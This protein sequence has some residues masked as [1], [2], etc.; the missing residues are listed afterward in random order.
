MTPPRA[1]RR[2]HSRSIHGETVADPWF[3]LRDRNDPETIA[4]L[5]A[6][7]RYTDAVM[8]PARALEAQLY[9]EMLG[10]IQ[11][12]DSSVPFLQG[13]WEYITRMEQGK[14]YP[15]H[16]RQ[17][18]G[19]ETHART[20]LD[21]NAL[22]AG[23]DYFSLAYSRVSP[24]GNV[25]AWAI[26]TDGSEVYTLRFRDLSTETSLPESITGVYYDA[27]WASDNLTFFYTT[28]DETRRPHR[29]WRHTL[30]SAEA[31][32]LV[33]EEPD[34]RFNVSIDRTR[35]GRFLLLNV[36]SHTTTE[37]R[38][39]DAGDATGEFQLLRPRSQDVEYFIEHQGGYFWMRTN[40]KAVNF[41]LLRA[42]DT[43]PGEWTEVLAHNEEVTLEGMDGFR[44]HLAITER[45]DG[46]RRIRVIHTPDMAQH[47]VPFEEPVYTLFP[48]RNEEYD[49]ATL[50]FL[51]TSLVTPR[52]VYDYDMST[53]ERELKKRYAVLGGYDP[54]QYVS[55]RIFATAPDGRQVP[56]SLVYRRGMRRDGTNPLYLNGYGSYGIVTE[57]AFSSDRISLLDRGFVFAIAHIRGSADKGR[58]W[59]ETG[60]LLH[61][62]NT[63]TD[64]IA[65]AE[66]LVAEGYTSPG[67]LV[68]VGGSAGGLLMGA[69]TNMRPDLFHAVVAHVPF[70]DVVNTMLDETLPLTVTEYEEWGNPNEPAFY[71]YI[72]SY[73]P[74]ENVT[75][76]H[77][78]HILA[79]AGLNDPRVPYWEPAKWVARLRE[80]ATGDRTMLLKTIMGAGHS[81]PSGRY[82]R[83]A[84][85]AFEYAFVLNVLE[86]P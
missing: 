9:A 47:L 64:F 67:K 77:Y 16:C 44:E 21:C 65:A 11:E 57:P 83:L 72:R 39:L 71:Q 60:K 56:V 3:W 34:A 73:A 31:D 55:E 8:A 33:F 13:G 36:N 14:Q 32:T 49:T 30:G 81:G 79:T 53:G 2:H 20:L 59:Y 78:P 50:R 41:R 51:Y 4:Y 86:R 75:A 58:R 80:V 17:R 68:I 46:L 42:L 12:T 27:A 40:E 5:D 63:F 10:R 6:E 62:R 38:F 15:I 70:V 19:S 76:Q 45:A 61:K 85:K 24:D 52:T 1:P 48:E 82:E 29:L 84:E 23:H 35:S 74:Y 43:A 22:A 28:L 7:N 26:D 54:H 37:Y 66:Y 25:L 18:P 69:V